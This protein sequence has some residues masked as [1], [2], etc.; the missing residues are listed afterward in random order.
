V[1][2]SV[3]G[4]WPETRLKALRGQG[5]PEVDELL[6]DL[7]EKDAG[8]I[9]HLYDEFVRAQLD[10]NPERWPPGLVGWWARPAPLP[11]W[12]SGEKIERAVAITKR[13]LPEVV[14][15]YVV[16][17]L[18]FAYAGAKGALV[19]SRISLLGAEQP[20]LRRVLETLLFVLRVNEAGALEVGGP[21]YTLARKTRVFHALVRVMLE[22]F[23]IDQRKPT[24]IGAPWN[25][26]VNGVPVNQEDLLGTLW[27]FAI[28][29]LEV[30]ERAGARL[31][32]ADKD[33]VVHR[34][35]VVGHL[36]GVGAGVSPPV[37]PLTYPEAAES[38][39]RIQAHQFR[40][41]EEGIELT[42]VLIAR[43]RGL[44]PVP[45]LRDLPA[46][47]MYDN[48]GP[49]HAGYVGVARPGVVRHLL[50]ATG[51]IFRLSLRV[52]GGQ[53]LRA[54]LRHFL[55]RFAFKWLRQER[56]GDRPRIELENLRR[57][58]LVPLYVTP[59]AR[60]SLRAR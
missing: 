54:P 57:R 58:R 40:R 22:S 35:C 20:L 16:A 31:S 1:S 52:P 50:H 2:T 14:T 39:A 36:L 10:L 26:A 46:A 59:A 55:K 53:L 11:E 34:W 48:L 12:A 45:V 37:F 21:G 41:S 27:T 25:C 47:A 24:C 28:T 51:A 4:A 43:C 33:A 17:S 9:L 42:K 15:S 56:E 44:I 7:R 32:D 3:S 23:A 18:P 19:L 13:W 5:D 30:I 49:T 29:P 38:W 8:W 6:G 60:R